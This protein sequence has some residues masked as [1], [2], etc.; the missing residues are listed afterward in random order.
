MSSKK[1]PDLMDYVQNYNRNHALARSAKAAEEVARA[2]KEQAR[3][4]KL[5]REANDRHRAEMEEL[6]KEEK[7]ANDRHRAEMK[8]MARKEKEANDRHRAEMKEMARKEKEAKEF[9]KQQQFKLYDIS[10][11]VK[12]LSKQDT[13]LLKIRLFYEI[14]ADF[15]KIVHDAIEDLKYRKLYTQV[16]A[17]L[18]KEENVIIQKYQ[19]ELLSY[20][21]FSRLK[22]KLEQF[23]KKSVISTFEELHEAETTLAE[24]IKLVDETP[25]LAIDT[26]ALQSSIEHFVVGTAKLKWFLA[27]LDSNK[28]APTEKRRTLLFSYYGA[29]EQI[30]LSEEW[31]RISPVELSAEDIGPFC[32]YAFEYLLRDPSFTD[33]VLEIVENIDAPAAEQTVERIKEEQQKRIDEEQARKREEKQYKKQYKKMV[34]QLVAQEDKTSQKDKE[35]VF[36]SDCVAVLGIVLVIAGIVCAIKEQILLG[37]VV[38]V[39]GLFVIRAACNYYLRKQK[40]KNNKQ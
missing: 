29:S 7:N 39:I 26:Q 32:N 9:T 37:G 33:T 34:K 30:I 5:D 16:E 4:A 25:E 28:I 1:E 11:Q 17:F 22:I 14:Q 8:E 12:E 20:R 40:Q 24:I 21:K 27:L 10:C 18:K 23:N 3:Q 19:N 35:I 31:E 6:A 13:V 38:I 36:T 2:K 15:E